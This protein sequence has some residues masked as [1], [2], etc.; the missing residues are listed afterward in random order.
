MA[1]EGDSA[2]KEQSAVTEEINRYITG[3]AVVMATL[4]NDAS[5]HHHTRPLLK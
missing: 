1:L 3:C 2:A 5:G 4:T